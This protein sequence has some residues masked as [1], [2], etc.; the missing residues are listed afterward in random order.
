[1]ISAYHFNAWQS[2]P[3]VLS[4]DGYWGSNSGN[5]LNRRMFFISLADSAKKWF[6]G[7]SEDSA[8]LAERVLQM[9]RGCTR[10]MLA[11]HTLLDTDNKLW[12]LDKCRSWAAK[13]DQYLVAI[14]AGDD[15]VQVRERIDK[16]VDRLV[17][18]LEEQAKKSSA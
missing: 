16:F 4:D 5:A 11:K 2:K 10:L 8:A 3:I 15:P 14:E 7:Q 13:L 12:L 18:E 17:G 9:R 1:M 6:A